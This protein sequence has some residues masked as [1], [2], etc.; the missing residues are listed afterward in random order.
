[1]SLHQ[2]VG[3]FERSR[4]RMVQEQLIAQGIQQQAVLDVM[5]EVPR[6]VFVEE[7]LLG[8]AYKDASLPIGQNQTISQPYM[9]AR[10]AELL[11]LTGDE[12][13][14]EI[15]TGCGYQSAVLSKLCRRVYSIERIESLYHLARKNLRKARCLSNILLRCGDGMQGWDDYAPFSAIVAAAG[16]SSVPL[17]WKQQLKD[18][19]YLLMPIEHQG[20]HVLLRLQRCGEQW[21]EEYFDACLFVPLLAGVK[22]A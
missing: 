19:G 4:K 18:G 22:H 10:L 16:G 12:R 8:H 15:G 5:G 13:V 3:N 14:L 21:K 1:V 20:Q 7:A 17:A 11:S 6:H 9:V 2:W